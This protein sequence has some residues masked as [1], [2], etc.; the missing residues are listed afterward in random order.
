MTKVMGISPACGVP[1]KYNNC[2]VHEEV[3]VHCWIV[4]LSFT[5]VLNRVRIIVTED[6][7]WGAIITL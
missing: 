4:N 2:C 6:A 5:S 3:D 7:N 1:P